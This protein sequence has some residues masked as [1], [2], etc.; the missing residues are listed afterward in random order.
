MRLGASV[1]QGTRK[2]AYLWASGLH[3]EVHPKTVKSDKFLFCRFPLKTASRCIWDLNLFPVGEEGLFSCFSEFSIMST[4][5]YERTIKIILRTKRS[6][7]AAG[8]LVGLPRYS[9]S[10]V[11]HDSF[12]PLTREAANPD[13]FLAWNL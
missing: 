7:L 2:L 13:Y 8:G 6:I 1:L 5:E 4:F 10:P 12:K 11:G 9:R 3:L